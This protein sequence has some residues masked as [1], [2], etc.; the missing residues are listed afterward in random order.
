MIKIRPFNS[1]DLDKLY[2]IDQKA[3]PPDIAYSYM[4]L[5]YYVRNCN[6][7]T[8]IAEDEDPEADEP[9]IGFVIGM[10]EPPDLGH[11]I[12]IEVVPHCR[13]HQVGSLLLEHI[14]RVFWQ[15]GAAAIYLECSVEDHPAIS[16][17]QKHGYFI[18]QR[19]EGYYDEEHDAFVLM[20]TTK[21]G[22]EPGLS[23]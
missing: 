9:I 6:G 22:G 10:W 21:C 23:E 20:K 7:K 19:L 5:Q 3:F 16:F 13:R 1:C 15:K 12:T 2:T 18:L 17:Y 4:E 14:E 8:L 11:I